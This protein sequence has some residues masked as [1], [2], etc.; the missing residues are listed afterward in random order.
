[1]S[2]MSISFSSLCIGP[3]CSRD[4]HLL[5]EKDEAGADAPNG[6]LG[7]HKLSEIFHFVFAK[8]N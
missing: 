2:V 6:F 1:M 8:S 7:R 3:I 5:S 4:D